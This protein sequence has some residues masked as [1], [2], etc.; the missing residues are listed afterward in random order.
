MRKIGMLLDVTSCRREGSRG[1]R[2]L[3]QVDNRA[4][5]EVEQSVK[6]CVTLSPGDSLDPFPQR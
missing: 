5:L 2:G 4:S 3:S 6:M 1:P